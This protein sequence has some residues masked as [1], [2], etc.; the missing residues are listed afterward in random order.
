MTALLS[1]GDPWDSELREQFK[2]ILSVLD[3]ELV[4]LFNYLFLISKKLVIFFV[5]TPQVASGRSETISFTFHNGKLQLL[6]LS[7]GDPWGSELR[8]QF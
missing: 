3:R 4:A 8:E 6:L 7:F 2:I 5:S 1:F